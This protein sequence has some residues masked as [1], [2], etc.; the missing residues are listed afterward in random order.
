MPVLG[1][2][3]D[4]KDIRDT[5]VRRIKNNIEKL[6]EAWEV[7]GIS[8]FIKMSDYVNWID[9]EDIAVIILDQRLTETADSGKEHVSYNGHQLVSYLR[10]TYKEIPIYMITTF[11]EDDKREIESKFKEFDDILSRDEFNKKASEYVS[12]FIRSGQKYIETQKERLSLL[13]TIS[14]K[15]A[16]GEATEDEVK[17]AKAIQKELEIPVIIESLTERKDWLT[18]IDDKVKELEKLNKEIEEIIKKKK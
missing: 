5:L 2:I 7:I 4:R 13:S 16:K 17:Q 10:Q 1:I 11:K 14:E 18:N 9:S 8:P 15:I 12:R 3:D 6:V